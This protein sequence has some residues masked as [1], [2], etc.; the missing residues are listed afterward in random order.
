MLP[1]HNR[2][3]ILQLSEKKVWQGVKDMLSGSQILPQD[4]LKLC[5]RFRAR[6]LEHT[7]NSIIF[8]VQIL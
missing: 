5:L 1:F 2:R 3:Y 8:L 6:S 4:N 7:D